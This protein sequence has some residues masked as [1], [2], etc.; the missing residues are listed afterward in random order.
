M[1]QKNRTKTLILGILILQSMLFLTS[2]GL[3]ADIPEEYSSSINLNQD[4]VYDVE[5]FEKG[6]VWAN[7]DFTA[8][9]KGQ[10]SCEKGGT[11]VVQVSKFDSKAVSDYSPSAFP[12]PAP[13]IDI[14]FKDAEGDE[15]FSLEGVANAEAAMNLA[16]SYN[17]FLSG[18]VIPIN[19]LSEL[20]DA[21][22][23]Q[24]SSD[25]F[26]PGELTVEDGMSNVK[27]TFEQESGAQT[28]EMWYDKNSGILTHAEVDND[29][30]PDLTIS[31]Q[32]STIPGYSPLILLGIVS[33]VAIII[34]YKKLR[35]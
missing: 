1:I 19:S 31:L 27:F 32:G 25:G 20:K 28:S 22:E 7:L 17:A 6:F 33:S 5:E 4:Y 29:Y 8:D 3:A 16:L 30:G 9:T 11:I 24:V 21:A 10:V 26:M 12:S 35:K 13:Y 15:T 34:A 2:I 23:A 18:F 14:I